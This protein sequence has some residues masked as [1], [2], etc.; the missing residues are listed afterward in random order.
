MK[1][2]DVLKKY[3]TY[4]QLK[5]FPK[6]FK[7]IELIGWKYINVYETNVKDE[8]ECFK[9]IAKLINRTDKRYRLPYKVVISETDSIDKISKDMFKIIEQIVKE[10]KT[11]NEIMK[12]ILSYQD[13]LILN[14]ALEVKSI[15][16]F[17][18]Y[19]SEYYYDKQAVVDVLKK[20]FEEELIF[21]YRRVPENLS[22]Q[23]IVN[24]IKKAACFGFYKNADEETKAVMNEI[25]YEVIHKRR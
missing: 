6:M 3:Y 7:R 22:L 23:N 17:N 18:L 12:D 2:Y 4:Q 16:Y 15:G 11:A 13:Y 10:A 9:E 21:T 25:R 20:D 5:V 24:A 8:R 19:E 1:I 14:R